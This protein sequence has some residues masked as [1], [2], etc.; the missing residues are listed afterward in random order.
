MD[1]GKLQEFISD[2]FT[3]R[4]IDVLAERKLVDLD[5]KDGTTIAAE[6]A[7]HILDMLN[8]DQFWDGVFNIGEQVWDSPGDLRI[9]CLFAKY[10]VDP[11]AEK[12]ECT[13]TLKTDAKPRILH[14]LAR[15]D[16]SR[17]VSLVGF[18]RTDDDQMDI[19]D[20]AAPGE[21][22]VAPAK[23]GDPNQT[24]LDTTPAL[25]WYLDPNPPILSAVPENPDDDNELAMLAMRRD[26]EGYL[27]GYTAHGAGCMSDQNPFPKNPAVDDEVML[28]RIQDM[29]TTWDRGFVT[30]AKGTKW[31]A[32]PGYPGPAE[33]MGAAAFQENDGTMNPF[34]DSMAIER[35][36]WD[37]GHRAAAAQV[38]ADA[39]PID[40]E[41]D[42]GSE[43]TPEEVA[44]KT[45][46]ESNAGEKATKKSKAKK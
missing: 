14:K 40:S 11:N 27:A 6:T 26:E 10:N 39:A 1:R 12:D 42:P 21:S 33:T 15:L 25:P 24:E 3:A 46:A 5:T 4:I 45:A 32:D 23:K 36:Q 34:G 30:A 22:P 28:E 8:R 7:E 43:P 13:L 19:E 20:D 37:A 38:K 41:P 9:G 31:Y 29:R 44:E 16:V 35:D 18:T 17:G 2:Q